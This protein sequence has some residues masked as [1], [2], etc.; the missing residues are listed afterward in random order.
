MVCGRELC[1]NSYVILL[2]YS[3][4]KC[5]GSNNIWMERLDYYNSWLVSFSFPDTISQ[6]DEMGNI[7]DSQ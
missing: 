3:G 2:D 6:E 4:K 5:V 1:S 7:K